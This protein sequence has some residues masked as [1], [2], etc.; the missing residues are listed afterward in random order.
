[1]GT[2]RVLICFFALIIQLLFPL[3]SH[4][5]LDFHFSVGTDFYRNPNFY[6]RLIIRLPISDDS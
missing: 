2:Q 6:L 3:F 5:L 4:F 1:M